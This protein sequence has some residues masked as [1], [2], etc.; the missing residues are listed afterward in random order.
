M[1]ITGSRQ[2]RIEKLLIFNIPPGKYVFRV[3]AI[4]SKGAWAEKKN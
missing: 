3:K 4:N 1:A 2:V